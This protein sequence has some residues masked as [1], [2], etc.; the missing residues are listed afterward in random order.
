MEK[1][2]R[3]C[4]DHNEDFIF[5]CQHCNQLICRSCVTTTHIQ[6]TLRDIK[7]IEK[8]FGNLTLHRETEVAV[9][10]VELSAKTAD[11]REP[12]G[13]ETKKELL[14]IRNPIVRPMRKRN[15]NRRL[16]PQ[17]PPRFEPQKPSQYRSDTDSEENE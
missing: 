5:L 17:L 10:K 4:T 9:K 11:L 8:L 13:Q 2:A 1:K 7:E 14:P 6:H 3:E 15:P 16:P 12:T